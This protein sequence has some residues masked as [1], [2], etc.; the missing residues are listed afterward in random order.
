MKRDPVCGMQVDEKRTPST[1]SWRTRWC[2][3][4]MHGVPTACPT[5]GFEWAG[6][7]SRRRPR[8]SPRGAW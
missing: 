4:T 7:P 3:S 2:R 5:A 8:P 1:G 6:A